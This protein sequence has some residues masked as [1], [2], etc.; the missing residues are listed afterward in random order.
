MLY[1]VITNLV[2][3]IFIFDA[4]ILSKLNNTYDRRVS[5]IYNEVSRL[6]KELVALGSDLWVFYGEPEP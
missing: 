5:F 1:E 6:K 4:A 3:P 2:Q